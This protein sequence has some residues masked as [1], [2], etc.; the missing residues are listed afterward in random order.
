M[1]LALRLRWTLKQVTAEGCKLS[2]MSPSSAPEASP[3]L[4]RGECITQTVCQCDQ[5]VG[6]TNLR[7]KMLILDHHFGAVSSP[8][9]G[10]AEQF[11]SW[12]LRNKGK[13][14]KRRR[15]KKKTENVQSKATL[16]R[17]SLRGE[18]TMEDRVYKIRVREGCG[19][20]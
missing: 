16:R 9:Q 11:T 20:P 5:S 6:E 2:A 17:N 8:W 1:T 7:E 14:N 15:Q 10:R 13:E 19:R 18:V 12:W 4:S 3:Q